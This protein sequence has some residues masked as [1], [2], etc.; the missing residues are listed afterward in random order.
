[1]MLDDKG[2]GVAASET[3]KAVPGYEGYY[4][5]STMGRVRSVERV[6]MLVDRQMK[7]RPCIY[8]S[9][10]LKP[11]IGEI[12]DRNILPRCQVVLSKDG[13]TRSVQVHRIIA[14]TFLP[15][16][17]SYET[18][19]HKD[20]DPMNNA[21]ENLEWATRR[22]N[23]RHAFRNNLIHTMKPVTMYDGDAPVVTFPSEA[24]ACR[25]MGISQGKVGAAA[26]AGRKYR[27]YYWRYNTVPGVPVEAW[28]G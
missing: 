20:G 22:Q 26:R 12:S 3:W 13:K 17:E 23:N 15:N 18:I 10:V 1:M 16:P 28:V 2:G 14:E 7:P 27:G 9:R 4:E 25:R 19:N 11:H 8:K 21:V 5:A 24:E 6:V